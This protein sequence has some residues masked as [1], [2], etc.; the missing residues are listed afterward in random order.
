MKA[1][2][3]LIPITKPIYGLYRDYIESEKPHLLV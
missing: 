3:D 1:A 2:M